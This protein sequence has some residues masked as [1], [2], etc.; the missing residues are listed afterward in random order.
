MNGLHPIKH[1]VILATVAGAATTIITFHEL[2]A[3]RVEMHNQFHALA[4]SS[5]CTDPAIR[6]ASHAVNKCDDAQRFIDG[7]TLSPLTYA[8]L[9]TMETLSVCGKGGVKCTQLASNVRNASMQMIALSAIVVMAIA[10][11]VVQKMKMEKQL[12]NDLPLNVPNYPMQ[13]PCYVNSKFN[14]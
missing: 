14:N 8:I 10:W 3:N 13:V 11:I 4:T 5:L 7:T 1:I 12:S 2:Y 6:L 9:E